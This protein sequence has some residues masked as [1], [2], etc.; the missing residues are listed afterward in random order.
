ME[1]VRGQTLALVWPE[2]LALSLT[3]NVLK[4]V[5]RVGESFL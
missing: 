3:L 2:T 4:L 5:M 1:F